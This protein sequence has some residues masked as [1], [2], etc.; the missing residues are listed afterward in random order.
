MT[1][2]CFDEV[3]VT[4]V[5]FGG[6]NGMETIP[7]RME[8]NGQIIYLYEQMR[9]QIKCGDKLTKLFDML[10]SSNNSFRLRSD[11]DTPGWRLVSVG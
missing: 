9:Y 2:N 4:G 5:R 8:F 1:R 7:T 10:D 11:S 6:K 3:S